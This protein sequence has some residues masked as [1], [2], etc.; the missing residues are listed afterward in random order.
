M[1]NSASPTPGMES[2]AHWP[3]MC[4]KGF[5]PS[6]RD[7]AEGLDVRRVDADVRDDADGRDQ[8]VIV[9]CFV[10]LPTF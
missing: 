1:E 6:R 7:D 10:H 5:L 3:G 9:S 4:S 2:I 8:R